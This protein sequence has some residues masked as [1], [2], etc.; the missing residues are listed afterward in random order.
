VEYILSKD[1]TLRVKMFSRNSQNLVNSQ[2]S[3]GGTLN[4]VAGFSLLHTK[5]F[6]SLRELFRKNPDEVEIPVEEEKKEEQERRKEE[7]PQQLQEPES[8]T[9]APLG[10]R[11]PK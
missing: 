8:K 4:T 6:D 7:E 9:T 3:G 1:G 5:S 11:P 2:M 10:L